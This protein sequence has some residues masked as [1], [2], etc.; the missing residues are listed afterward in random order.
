MKLRLASL[1]IK[2]HHLGHERLDVVPV[3]KCATARYG[4]KIFTHIALEK[5]LVIALGKAPQDSIVIWL[6]A[7]LERIDQDQPAVRFEHTRCFSNYS[8]A[9]FRRQFMHHKDTRDRIAALIGEGDVFCIGDHEID[10]RPAL[11]MPPGVSDIGLGEVDSDCRQ[12]WPC[13]HYPTSYNAVSPT[14]LR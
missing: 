14:Q 6:I 7:T 9:H 1:L 12:A 2:N 4:S 3:Y 10:A 8:A 5:R 13:L 11:E